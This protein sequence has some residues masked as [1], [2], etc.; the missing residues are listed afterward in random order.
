[1][2][3]A[4]DRLYGLE[5]V[6]CSDTEVRAR[7]LVRDELKQPCGLVH[8]GVYASIAESIASVATALAVRPQGELAMGLVEQHE[9]PAPDHRGQ[10]ARARHA[11]APRPH[12]VGVGRELQRRL[13]AAR[14]RSRA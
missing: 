4:I 3:G 5:L 12:D 14:A 8:G 11:R 1:M 7:V 2:R 10:R 9:L 13:R 6:A